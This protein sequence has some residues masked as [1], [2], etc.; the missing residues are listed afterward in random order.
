[1]SEESSKTTPD[2]EK[3]D[4]SFSDRFKKFVL[5]LK[6]THKAYKWSIFIAALFGPC[7]LEKFFEK[8]IRCKPF[9]NIS[10]AD[11]VMYCAAIC[12]AYATLLAVVLSIRDAKEY[13][14][15]VAIKEVRPYLV[16]EISD[17][18]KKE[19]RK[20]SSRVRP[21]INFYSEVI[22]GE[23]WLELDNA[24]KLSIKNI[25]HGPAINI[26][27]DTMSEKILNFDCQ[28]HLAANESYE[29]VFKPKIPFSIEFNETEQEEIHFLT[30]EIVI[31]Y[32]DLLGTDYR[33]ETTLKLIYTDLDRYFIL[34]LEKERKEI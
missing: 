26:I 13:R 15:E 25:G 33:V 11:W 19:L 27:L 6:K 34:S 14:K 28:K 22:D 24:Y 12:G 21:F 1:M 31:D 32:Y 4:Q 20:M 7:L 2:K 17:A 30:H 18:D 16:F 23:E 5:W 29:V 10:A 3:S 9:N 8:V